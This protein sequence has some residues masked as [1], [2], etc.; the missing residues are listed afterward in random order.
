MAR[1]GGA[2]DMTGSADR[3]FYH[4][5]RKDE[6]PGGMPVRKGAMETLSDNGPEYL[7]SLFL[8]LPISCHDR[9]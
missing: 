6:G 5:S 4:W 1:G 3:L 7:T 8:S 2:F 9:H